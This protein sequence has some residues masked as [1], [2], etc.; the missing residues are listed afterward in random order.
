MKFSI[1]LA[2]MLLVLTAGTYAHAIQPGALK[3]VASPDNAFVLA[4]GRQL[5]LGVSDG[6]VHRVLTSNGYSEIRITRRRMT[7]ARA[8]ACKGGKKYDV[9]IS[10]DG[11]IRRANEI[12]SCRR[13]IDIGIAKQ[14]LHKTGF[15]KIQIN[16]SGN[17]FLAVACRGRN[18][19]RLAMNRYGDIQSEKALGRCGGDLGVHDIVAQL[20]ARGFSRIRANRERRGGFSAVAC[21]GD[22]KLELRIDNDGFVVSERSTG[23]CD[24]AIH[25]ANIPALLARYGFSRVEVIDRQLPRYM[26]QACRDVERVEVSLDRY[27]EIVDERRIGRCEPALSSVQLEALLREMGYGSVQIVDKHPGGFIAEVCDDKARLQLSLTVYGET[28]SQKEL[29]RCES[30]RVRRVL[31]DL[32]KRGLTNPTMFVVGCRKGMRVR[33]ELD[34]YGSVI[35]SKMKG[36]CPQEKRSPSRRR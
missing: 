16:P 9:E 25:P 36:S 5:E 31:K 1:R 35:E 21:R 7:K 26:A 27:G 22:N 14:I 18:R 34:R 8:E 29:G 6:L 33:L 17:G 28:V 11:R 12:G 13:E 15:R 10:F 24:P 4:Q 32:E 19:L 2:A 20:R 3:P 23:R 30:R